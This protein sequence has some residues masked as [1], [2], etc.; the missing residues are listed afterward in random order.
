MVI[1]PLRTHGAGAVEFLKGKR[2]LKDKTVDVHHTVVAW[3]LWEHSKQV[4]VGCGQRQ[5]KN[6]KWTSCGVGWM[7]S[8]PLLVPHRMGVL[9]NSSFEVRSRR[10]R[11]TDLDLGTPQ[12]RLLNSI[13]GT[14]I[15][16]YFQQS[17]EH[18]QSVA[19]DH[20]LPDSSLDQ[21]AHTGNKKSCCHKKE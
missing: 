19:Q 4:Y 9:E 14:L 13:S 15:F 6:G 5:W 18:V 21:L 3:S 1:V 16:H 8:Q 20:I 17:P 7:N 12:V 11:V 2:V 10:P